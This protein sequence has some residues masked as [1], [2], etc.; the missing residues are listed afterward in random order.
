MHRNECGAPISGTDHFCAKCG[1][2]V[3]GQGLRHHPKGDAKVVS[4][5]SVLYY[6]FDCLDSPM[7]GLGLVCDCPIGKQGDV[8][9]G[10]MIGF[11]LGLGF[12]AFYWGV[13]SVVL[14]IMARIA[15][16]PSQT[17]QWSGSTMVLTGT[18]ATLLFIGGLFPRLT[19]TGTGVDSK[20]GN[21]AGQPQSPA[22]KITRTISNWTG[23]PQWS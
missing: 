15:T 9:A 14:G 5:F 19:A 21:A 18:L 4:T 11:G 7:G 8:T 3:S 23:H 16:R 2:T 13:P 6:C 1:N 22:W 17:V 10:S 20:A 12:Y